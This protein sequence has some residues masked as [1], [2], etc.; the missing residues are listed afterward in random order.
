VRTDPDGSCDSMCVLYECGQVR[1]S[2]PPRD[3][4]ETTTMVFWGDDKGPVVMVW[5]VMT[6]EE[7]VIVRR[8]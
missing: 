4:E 7:Q 2:P 5:D 8:S 1:G 6:Q 3:S